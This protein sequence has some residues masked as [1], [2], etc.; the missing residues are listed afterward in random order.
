MSGRRARKPWRRLTAC[1]AFMSAMFA[2]TA[3]FGLPQSDQ[4]P[5]MRALVI[6]VDQYRYVP[7]LRGA[8]ADSRDLEA[9]LRKIGV[10]DLTILL[11]GAVDRATALRG[12]DRL[13]AQVQPN[14]TVFLA[15]AGHGA[16]EPERVKGSQPDGMEA[17][18]LM[19]GFD[20][21]DGKRNGEKILHSEF[22]HYIKALEEKGARVVFVADTCS[23]GGLAR[24]VDPRGA[25]LRYR[26]VSYTPISDRIDPVST[27]AEA[28]LAPIDFKRSVF[29]AAVDKQSKVPEVKIEGRGYRGALSYALA[30]GFEGGADLSGDGRITTDE[31]FE[32]A[33]RVV[34]QLSDA[35]QQI[36]TSAPPTVDPKRDII[37]A[38]DRG[39]SVQ[40][41][42]APP[43]SAGGDGLEILPAPPGAISPGQIPA[44]PQ[45]V[46]APLPPIKDAIR[47]A[48][49][50]GKL[51]RGEIVAAQ[52]RFDIVSADASPDLVY[53]IST[54][55]VI[56]GGDVL[57]RN[58]EV[59][60]LAGVI[61]RTAVVK[62]LQLRAGKGPQP[63]RVFPN[64]QV[65]RR[66]DQIEVS[67][68]GVENR[69][70]VLFN[71]SGDGTVQFLYPVGSDPSLIKDREHRLTL[72]A[73]DPLG[74]DQIV[75]ITAS[76]DMSQLKQ[77]IQ[78]LDRSRR[79]TRIPEFVN[80]FATGDALVGSVGIFTAP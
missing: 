67:I 29:L 30:R 79:A 27:A 15:L 70:L 45:S 49:R 80:Q 6:G 28:A 41:V 46:A 65:H 37:V 14:D 10:K 16:L 33:R 64:D 77:A 48:A 47:I 2:A 35:R 43:Q 8:V 66:G 31:M 61:D 32:Y 52:A 75:A 19:P 50:G 22:N 68:G 58:V 44:S 34:Y 74:A 39:V 7:S 20:P 26:S 60:D 9:A 73:K 12:F 72:Q 76:Q 53:D 42:G 55:E 24:T 11:D 13:V 40:A 51:E 56:G 62:W 36:V 1:C 38:L 17:V 23:G 57:A 63:V 3:S 21:R 25:Q 4:P 71:I 78:A 69:S 5:A 18:F 54:Q 59:R